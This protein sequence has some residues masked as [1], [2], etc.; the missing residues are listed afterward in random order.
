M[1]DKIG[2]ILI[3]DDDGD[4]LKA[5]R[6]LLKKHSR[7]IHT[8]KDP[9]NIPSLLKGGSYDVILLDMNFTRDVT[10]GQEGLHWLSRILS[11]DPA[12]VVIMITVQPWSARR[13][14]SSKRPCRCG[15]TKTCP[16]A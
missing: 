1:A 4:V 12:A 6:L 5:A 10:S 11:I 14:A 13:T 15:A 3:V 16:R 8:E 9:E 7:S 2:N